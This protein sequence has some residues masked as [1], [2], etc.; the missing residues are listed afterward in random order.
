[1]TNFF[2]NFPEITYRFPTEANGPQT[3][4]Q[5]SIILD[6]SVDMETTQFSND[7]QRAKNIILFDDAT[8]TV[9]ATDYV[10]YT[11]ASRRL[12]LQPSSPLSPSKKYRILV[13]NKL[14]STDGRKSVNEYNWVFVTASGAIT[15]P[16]PVFPGDATVQPTFPTLSWLGVT[17]TSTTGSALTAVYEV[18]VDETWEFTSL[19]YS[20]TTTGL[21]ATPAGV[22]TDNTTYYWRVRAYT[23]EATGAWSDTKSFYYG[24]ALDSDPSTRQYLPDSDPFGVKKLGFKDGSSNLSAHPSTLS[25][26]FT[27]APASNY[28]SYIEVTKKSVLPRNDDLTTYDESTLAGS[29]SA[30]GNTITFTPSEAIAQNTRYQ[31][32]LKPEMIN[33]SGYELGNEE[34]M[35]WTGRYSPFY[36]SPR[37]IRSRFLGA[38][39]K[40]PDDLINFYIYQ[41]SLEA[42]A[43]YWGYQDTYPT[44]GDSLDE[45]TVRDS[46]NLQSYGVL[47]W[48]EAKTAYQLL[49]AIL[50]EHLRDIGRTE[51]LGDTFVSLTA[52]FVK[53]ID[54]AL[55][56]VEEE[57]REWENYLIPTDIPLTVSRSSGWSPVNWDYDLAVGGLEAQR[58][59]GFEL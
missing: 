53:G 31:I 59:N 1:M 6:W 25:I 5:P 2:G 24:R 9:L 36:V 18:H 10:S 21:A 20:T 8:S 38:E 16:T 46:G 32:L 37:V 52:D 27:S 42:N 17:V 28:T 54:K 49:K 58:D 29:W 7:S 15:V 47:K 44:T 43:R 12:T 45:I 50:F 22:F 13:K 19:A 11:A 35:Y 55:A 14:Q 48:V 33:T 3:S 23:T 34:M 57:I 39:Q 4:L 26:T 30:S 51:K 56:K 40:V 41:A